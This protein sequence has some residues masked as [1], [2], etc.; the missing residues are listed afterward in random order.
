[1]KSLAAFSNLNG[2]Y[3][4]TAEGLLGRFD[5]EHRLHID[6]ELSR[7]FRDHNASLIER[8]RH[9][10]DPAGYR[11][12]VI[13]RSH[14]PQP[15]GTDTLRLDEAILREL[16]PVGGVVS[17]TLTAFQRKNREKSIY[18]GME[19]LLEYQTQ[20]A[21]DAAVY[22]PVLLDARIGLA[23]RA[24][25][26]ALAIE[27]ADPQ[28]PVLDL[29]NLVA[30]IP[31]VKRSA[32]AITQLKERIHSGTIRK[33]E[34]R[35]HGLTLMDRVEL[36]ASTG[37]VADAFD[38]QR[39]QALDALQPSTPYVI[40][41]PDSPAAVGLRDSGL[42]QR[43]ER[44]LERPPEPASPEMIRRFVTFADLDAER[45]A[46]IASHSLVFRV[47]AGAPLLERGK[48]DDWNLY[49]VDGAVELV[50]ADG[51]H[52]IVESGTENARNPIAFLRP[53]MFSVSA[54]TRVA[55]VWI[56]DSIV[57]RALADS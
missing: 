32:P 1:M 3:M 53:R 39:D 52:R 35:A 33:D 29:L 45:L 17:D 38:D 26:P 8:Y 2:L 4:L 50:A 20:A 34:R 18:R 30:P 36:P 44:W 22:C 42:V 47:P 19:L 37:A 23:Q 24:G 54:Y 5:G 27:D 6:D 11:L 14:R 43:L 28:A 49:L 25:E 40:L 16:Y 51:G 13:Y 48:H 57:A 9:A 56:H 46:L 41:E 31:V 15:W 10:P 21:P 12:G 7:A 55:F